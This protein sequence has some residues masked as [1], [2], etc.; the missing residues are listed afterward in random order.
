[1]IEWWRS[2]HGAPTDPKWGVIARVAGAPRTVVVALA[3]TL[4]DAASKAPARGDVSGADP[5]ELAV[6]LDVSPDQVAAIMDAMRAANPT[7]GKPRFIGADGCI[8]EWERYQPK[9]EDSRPTASRRSPT[10]QGGGN[11]GSCGVDV[12]QCGAPPP[13]APPKDSRSSEPPLTPPAGGDAVDRVRSLVW[14]KS[15]LTAE[16]IQVKLVTTDSNGIRQVRGWFALGLTEARIVATINRAFA[17]AAEPIRRPWPY[18]DAVMKAEAERPAAAVEC[19]AGGFVSTSVD[20]RKRLSDFAKCG[21]WMDG[22]GEKPGNSRCE[23]PADL[24]AEF[25][26]GG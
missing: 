21:F 18:L 15:G 17:E 26:F 12:G 3:W 2:W 23:A 22:W 1:M 19:S 8:T 20:W 16:A 5:E 4:L 24:L 10:K 6:A 9:R 25:G 14:S 11:A 7:S 13:P